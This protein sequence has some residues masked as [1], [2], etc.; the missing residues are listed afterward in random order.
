MRISSWACLAITLIMLG[1][2]AAGPTKSLASDFALPSGGSKILVM[3]PTADMGLISA[4]GVREARA[5]WT[6]TAVQN[7]LS[8][9]E[10]QLGRHGAS[11][12]AYDPARPV[13]DQTLLLAE[14]VMGTAMTYGPGIGNYNAAL[15]LPTKENNFDYTLGEAV[16]G[17]RETY[18]TDYAL[19]IYARGDFASAANQALQVG[20]GILFGGIV[21]P[22][23]GQRITLASLVDLETG[24]LVWMDVRLMGDARNPKEADSIVRDLVARIPVG[25]P[26]GRPAE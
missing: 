7:L 20:I 1:A 4:A 26:D 8:S 18:G 21:I 14:T 9:F 2:C 15:T 24:D 22:S 3:E 17:L 19:F 11:I 23:G 13:D 6:E 10:A 16:S 25:A 12:V 5:D